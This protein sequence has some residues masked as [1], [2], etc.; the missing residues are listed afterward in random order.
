MYIITVSAII[1]Y[2]CN[3]WYF[4]RT[5]FMYSF[6]Y[7]CNYNQGEGAKQRQLAIITGMNDDL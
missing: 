5:K 1:Q 2:E 6:T 3:M 4:T 7:K